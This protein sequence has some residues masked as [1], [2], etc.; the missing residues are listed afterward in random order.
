MLDIGIMN[1]SPILAKRWFPQCTYHGLDI[2]ASML[3]QSES[4]KIDRLFIADLETDDLEE[5]PDG[6]YDVIVVNHVIE[7]LRNGLP[8]LTR[9][10][11][12]LKPGGH[13][14]VEFPSVRS[15]SFPSGDGT[16]NFQDDPTH[17]R[18]YTLAEVAN[19]L[20]DSGLKIITA[21]RPK[22]I[23]RTFLWFFLMIPLQIFNLITRRRLHARGLTFLL[24]FSDFVY[25]VKPPSDK[26]GAAGGP[27]ACTPSP[28]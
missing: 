12:K 27:T 23:T 13:L 6:L 4:E 15:L 3:S 10:A 7:H 8:A 26:T 21:G 25:A 22:G 19:N 11:E 18:V 9:L 24:G 20:M 2:S 1:G 5:V 14:Y 16:L 28:D 17:V